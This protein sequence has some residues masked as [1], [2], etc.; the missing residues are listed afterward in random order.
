MKSEFLNTYFR[1]PEKPLH[2]PK[3]FV[4]ITA[5]N[6][7]GVVHKSVEN[8]EFDAALAAYLQEHALP[9]WRVIGG[10]HDFVHAEP[11]YGVET[12]LNQ[13]IELGV[14]FRQEAVFY[15]RGDNLFLVDCSTHQQTFL[16]GFRPRIIP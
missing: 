2:L 11:G 5:F 8:N 4:I 12:D 1:I 14:L 15:V 13:G 10:S 6:P 9:H 16:G 3:E 7:R